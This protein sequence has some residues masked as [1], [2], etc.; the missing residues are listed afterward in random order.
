MTTGKRAL[1]GLDAALLCGSMLQERADFLTMNCVGGMA[2]TVGVSSVS[3]GI[4]DLSF[5][6][7]PCHRVP[8]AACGQ[9]TALS[10]LGQATT[11][12]CCAL[13]GGRCYPC[14]GGSLAVDRA[15]NA[16]AYGDVK[17]SQILDGTVEP[18]PEMQVR[19]GCGGSCIRAWLGCL[20]CSREPWLAA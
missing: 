9:C 16:A 12:A 2:D 5:A 15:K 11:Q 14:S 10:W 3:G 17:A 1:R 6:G 4:F 20:Q 18:P 13:S 7:E 19:Q 8:A